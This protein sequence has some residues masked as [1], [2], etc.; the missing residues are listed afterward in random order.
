MA[1]PRRRAPTFVHSKPCSSQS[2]AFSPEKNRPGSILFALYFVVLL[3]L[4]VFFI[5]ISFSL[6]SRSLMLTLEKPMSKHLKINKCFLKVKSM[7]SL[8]PSDGLQ[9]PPLPPKPPA[10]YVGWPAGAPGVL[11]GGAVGESSGPY[12]AAKGKWSDVRINLGGFD[13]EM[14]NGR[15]GRCV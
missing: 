6:I 8:G 15:G 11:G 1:R 9:W 14:V 7:R 12:G 3:L 5:A 4:L 2:L 10:P 13:C